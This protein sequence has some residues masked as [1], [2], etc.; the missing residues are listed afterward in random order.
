MAWQAGTA[1]LKLLQSL[2]E[3]GDVPIKPKT[4]Q[5]CHMIYELEVVGVP[6]RSPWWGCTWR[7]ED[8]VKLLMRIARA[9][10]PL[11]VATK[12]LEFYSVKLNLV[13]SGRV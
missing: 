13:L 12:T 9:L 3:A 6:L 7:D 4:H 8:S 1:L 2:G 11:A 10:H 5:L